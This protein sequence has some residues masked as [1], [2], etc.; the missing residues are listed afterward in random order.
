MHQTQTN[1]IHPWVGS[2]EPLIF[3][4]IEC[5]NSPLGKRH[6]TLSTLKR[7]LASV[8]A[9]VRSN[10]GGLGE[11]F[12][13]N[14][15]SIGFLSCVSPQ[16]CHQ[17][18]WLGKSFGTV[19]ALEWF[20]ATMAPHMNNQRRFAWKS[21][22][23]DFALRF[24]FLHYFRVLLCAC[25]GKILKEKSYIYYTGNWHHDESIMFTLRLARMGSPPYRGGAICVSQWPLELCR[26]ESWTP[27]RATHAEQ[28]RG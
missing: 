8:S 25:K 3:Y 28:V 18:C 12:A 5:V 7:S 1:Q 9:H 14:R 16:V 20:L 22:V 21:F 27:G 10:R 17:V 26:R 6:S 15:T 13:T 4:I 2:Q 24:L 23:T 19:A 11:A